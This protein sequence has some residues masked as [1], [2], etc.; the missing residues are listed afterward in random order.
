MAALHHPVL[1]SPARL[2]QVVLTLLNVIFLIRAI[3]HFTD[4]VRC[5]NLTLFRG[6]VFEIGAAVILIP[7][8]SPPLTFE[9]FF[10][11]VMMM[12]CSG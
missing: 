1:F 11:Q 5:S 4:A 7:L 9:R 6:Q 2:Q 10:R 12:S 8:S 3:L